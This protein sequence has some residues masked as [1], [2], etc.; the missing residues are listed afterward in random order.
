MVIGVRH[1]SPACARLVRHIILRERPS[2]VLI[3]GPSD[4]ND[5]IDELYLEHRLPMAIYSY[6]SQD[7][8]QSGEAPGFGYASWSPF[9][10]YSP[11]WVGLRAAREVGAEVF[12]IDL[13]AG[14][15]AFMGM[16]NRYADRKDRYEL[17]LQALCQRF[18]ETDGDALWDHLFESPMP[19]DELSRR[20]GVYFD[21]LRG[22]DETDAQTQARE[23]Y[24]ASWMAW[25]ARAPEKPGPIVVIC[26]GY[27]ASALRTLWKAFSK[28]EQEGR[29]DKHLPMPQAQSFLVP[30]SF[31]RLDAF[32]GYDAGMPSP[33]F[34]Q[35]VWENG[36]ETA[37]ECML[38]HALAELRGKQQRIS[39]ADAI[40]ASSAMQGLMRIRGHQVPL[41]VDMLDGLAS[42]L[43][44]D[45]LE[46]PLPWEQ[47]GRL[48]P[49]TDP[50]L[51]AVL[52]SLSG[53]QRGELAP[54]TRRP[55]LYGD[56]MERLEKAGIP[57]TQAS[58]T[59]ELRL[60]DSEPGASDRTRSR[61]LHGLRVL[62]IP[63]FQCGQYAF[64]DK[65][66][67]TNLG[68]WVET[69]LIRRELDVDSALIEA[70][71]Y[72]AT[73]PAAAAARIEEMLSAA[74][75]IGALS[76]LYVETLRVG[77]TSLEESTL[78][79]MLGMIGTEPSFG[80]VGKALSRLMMLIRAGTMFFSSPPRELPAL[81]NACFERGLWLFEGLSGRKARMDRDDVMAVVALRE[82]LLVRG[83]GEV[84]AIGRKRAEALM[85]RRIHDEDA[86]VGVAGA[87]LGC[88]WSVFT[89]GGDAE[90]LG[91]GALEREAIAAMRA[92]SLPET[93]G[94]F[95]VGLFALARE[96]VQ[97][98]PALLS[99]LDA[100]FQG[101]SEG[102]FLVAA[103]SLRLAFSYFPPR[104]RQKIAYQILSLKGISGEQSFDWMVSGDDPRLVLEGRRLELEVSDLERRY[105][106][107]SLD[108]ASPDEV[109]A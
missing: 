27:H 88:L 19:L 75:G 56:A 21:E 10:D 105:G 22:D 69:W 17:R 11:E 36:P 71:A 9:C 33:A 82:M 83:V 54:E 47:R 101:M 70:S 38:F 95:L 85:R 2:R 96:A 60:D 1:H 26:G 86:P 20:L 102:D 51:V 34:Y 58:A 65:G 103:P 92:A 30:Y 67:E 108:E 74:R 91:A 8:A 4:V 78:R 13:P 6:V 93:L 41:R 94:D 40:A 35:C 64:L 48:A 12:F 63:G 55:P 100:V 15:K 90:G 14:H 79:Q 3:E 106:L 66:G 43:V 59:V 24:M 104:E 18:G 73:I 81:L 109:G 39:P 7:G 29:P 45:A 5:W 68:S 32:I 57:Y 80:S 50:M 28:P 76:A 72:G 97:K 87:A 49:R 44:K 42:V 98:A 61:L 99:A 62:C 89:E 46:V 23:A 37:A 107:A 31:R 25:A 77:A 16:K 53:G 84:D 52:A